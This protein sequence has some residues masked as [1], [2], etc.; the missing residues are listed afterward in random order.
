MTSVVATVPLVKA[1]TA[2]GKRSCT[3]AA[4]IQGF[5]VSVP[6]PAFA[7]VGVATVIAASMVCLMATVL[8][9]VPSL[10]IRF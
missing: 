4:M 6:L 3:G 10:P 5:F 7:F 8:A 2:A 9:R 1:M